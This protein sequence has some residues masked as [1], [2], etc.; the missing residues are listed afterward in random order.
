MSGTAEGRNGMDAEIL[1]IR[2]DAGTYRARL[3]LPGHAGAE[4]PALE[5]RHRGA[6]LPEVTVSALNGQDWQ[7][8]APLPASLLSDGVQSLHLTTAEGAQVLHGL[9]IAAGAALEGDLAAEV[10]LLRD[11]LEIVKAALRRLVAAQA[12]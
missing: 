10:A 8:S 7:V 11:E 6:P 12:G 9:A 1:D 3:R 2:L 4:P 5:L